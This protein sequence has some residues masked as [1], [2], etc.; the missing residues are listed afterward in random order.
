M[1]FIDIYFVAFWVVSLLAA[2]FNSFYTAKQFFSADQ[3]VSE[4]TDTSNVSTHFWY[5]K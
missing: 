4:E 1:S 2:L 3:W 5:R